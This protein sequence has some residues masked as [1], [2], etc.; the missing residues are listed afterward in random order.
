MTVLLVRMVRSLL[1]SCPAQ[2]ISVISAPD[3][4]ART[5]SM[6]FGKVKRCYVWASHRI[7]EGK[8]ILLQSS[9]K[10]FYKTLF[11]PASRSVWRCDWAQCGEW[12]VWL[13]G[14]WGSYLVKF[15]LLPNWDWWL[16]VVVV[17]DPELSW[18]AAQSWHHPLR[19]LERLNCSRSSYSSTVSG[20]A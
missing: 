14:V 15:L 11:S 10:Y 7:Q 13:V 18:R 12:R 6:W 9:P 2:P 5:R 19:D 8:P 4:M 3:N 16:V 20:S 17:A 1:R